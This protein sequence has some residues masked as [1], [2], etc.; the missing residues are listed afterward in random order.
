MQLKFLLLI[1]ISSTFV[2]IFVNAYPS[3]R[4]RDADAWPP[5]WKRDAV[6]NE[7]KREAEAEAWG[8]KREAEANDIKRDAGKYYWQKYLFNITNYS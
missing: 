5:D 4:K 7:F 1:F 6:A 8:Y 3:G 2:S